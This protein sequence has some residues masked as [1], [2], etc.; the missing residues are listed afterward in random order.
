[1]ASAPNTVLAGLP[2]TVAERPDSG[3]VDE[4]VQRPVGAAMGNLDSQGLL[5]PAQ[6]GKTRN[7]PVQPRKPEPTGYHPGGLTQGEPKET[8]D[9]KSDLDGIGRGICPPDG[10]LILLIRR[11]P[12]A[13]RDALLAAPASPYPRRPRSEANRAS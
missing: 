5:A 2:F 10:F 1:M 9:R 7:R 11:R 6:G 4:Q 8:Q 12:V 13:V 3:A